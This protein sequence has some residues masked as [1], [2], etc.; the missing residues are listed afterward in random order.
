MAAMSRLRPALTRWRKR[1]ARGVTICV[2]IS[3]AAF[4]PLGPAH[5]AAF[6]TSAEHAYLVDMGTGTVLLS[7]SADVPVAPASMAKL[8][9]LEIAFDAIAN[10]R[11]SL[12]E[13][14]VVSEHAWRTGGAPARTATM[15][16][17]VNSTV[18][19]S[20]LL[21]GIM[22]QQAN[23]AAIAIGEGMAGSEAAFA[24][25]MNE[26]ARELGLETMRFVNASGLAGP[27]GETGAASMRDLVK[28][29]IHIIETYPDLYGIF[30]EPEFTWNNIRQTNR[31]PV[32]GLPIGAD[33]LIPAF[34]E[35]TGFGMV[36]S[37][38]DKGQRLVLAVHGLPN[39]SARLSEVQK[40]I[41]WG[42]RGFEK[43]RLFNAGEVVGEIGVFGGAK[44]KV[45]LAGRRPIEVL[46]PKGQRDAVRAR[47]AYVGPLAA[48]VEEGA[49]VAVLRVV[50]G[51][52]VVA[53]IPLHT[54]EG[55]S[56]GALYQRAFDA[57]VE[58][59]IGLVHS[60]VEAAS[61]AR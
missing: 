28:L 21:R 8:M 15:F 29:T 60:G 57:A 34:H 56:Q 24:E 4:A 7:K 6:E 39:A 27:D 58:L 30:S 41:L 32:I 49:E 42:F 47:I 35:G 51:D 53:E 1:F 20:N 61:A 22:V 59:M 26:R 55:V 23:D 50:D 25:L 46:L 19:V 13:T 31:N 12:D 3:V 38:V 48:P 40:L 54:I 44:G 5:A 37:A 33:G 45:R 43:V 10:G 9:T 11:L 52:T 18:E 17:K 2:A 14:L 36:A 16:A